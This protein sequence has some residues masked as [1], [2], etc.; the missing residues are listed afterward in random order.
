M[1]STV[2]PNLIKKL[3]LVIVENLVTEPLDKR[4][5]STVNQEWGGSFF[6]SMLLD[7]SAWIYPRGR[8]R[9]RQHTYFEVVDVPRTPPEIVSSTF[10]LVAA[11]GRKLQGAQGLELR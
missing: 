6:G 11:E 2:S 4:P 7:N 3:Q 8:P 5:S 1:I 10:L 9:S